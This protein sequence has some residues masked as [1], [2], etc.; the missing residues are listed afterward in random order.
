MPRFL[1]VTGSFGTGHTAVAETV[2][3]ELNRRLGEGSAVI[4]D[5]L[6]D[7][8]PLFAKMVIHLY[9]FSLRRLPAGYRVVYYLTEGQKQMNAGAR[10]LCETI[11]A[12]GIDRHV[13]GGEPE[14]IVCT[15]PFPMLAA[16]RRRREGK[17]GAKIIA[18][19]TDFAVHP[20]WIDPDVDMYMV[21]TEKTKQIL[22]GKG[23]L[24]ERVHVTGIPIRPVFALSRDKD[25]LVKKYGLN[26]KIPVLL[27]MGGGLGLGP[28]LK[29]IDRINAAK[30]LV[31]VVVVAGT[32]EVLYRT[33]QTSG[34]SRWK[35]PVTVFPYIREVD[36]LM[37][38]ASILIT[39]PGAVT[40]SEAL[41]KRLPVVCDSP[42]PGH[43]EDNLK[44]LDDYG[45]L[46]TAKKGAEIHHVVADLLADPEM[47]D[48][49]KA[50]QEKI[51]RPDAVTE[52]ADRLLGVGE[53]AQE[54]AAGSL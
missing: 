18:L 2:A 25:E 45:V 15:H 34:P 14:M 24:P 10:W 21:A 7:A 48:M 6:L 12:P 52:V 8:H 54:R 42:I 3:A 38:I 40:I 36:E 27:I 32:N 20:L 31:Q 29:W 53:T 30:L 4:A 46:I 22:L 35:I 33:I 9:L 43:E 13:A 17:I 44:M 50:Q 5:P 28:I 39:K 41:V 47:L 1:F 26:P 51:A 49:M 19:I 16:I 37:E 11:I 23:I